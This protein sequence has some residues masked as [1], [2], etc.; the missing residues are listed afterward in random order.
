MED[1]MACSKEGAID[2]YAVLNIL[3]FE[4]RYFRTK[5]FTSFNDRNSLIKLNKDL[6]LLF[7]NSVFQ[8]IGYLTDMD[9]KL[10]FKFCLLWF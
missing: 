7:R 9:F 5:M 4:F 1:C 3:Y 2:F 6:F 10:S 8:N